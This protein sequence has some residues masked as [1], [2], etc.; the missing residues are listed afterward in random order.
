M[1]WYKCM[2]IFQELGIPVECIDISLTDICGH[3][4]TT[5]MLIYKVVNFSKFCD[6]KNAFLFKTM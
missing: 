4:K 1:G 2:W 5:K 6:E 3:E